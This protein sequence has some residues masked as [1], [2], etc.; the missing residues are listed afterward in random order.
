MILQVEE[1]INAREA[2]DYLSDK[3]YE[4]ERSLDPIHLVGAID[5]KDIRRMRE[6]LS[7]LESF[8][9]AFLDAEIQVGAPEV[10]E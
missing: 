8:V 2:A 10:T 3:L 1:I 5:E 9:E 4:L 6:R 7:T